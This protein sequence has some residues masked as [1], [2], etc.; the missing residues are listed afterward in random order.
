MDHGARLGYADVLFRDLWLSRTCRSD[1]GAR[2][3]L[4]SRPRMSLGIAGVVDE[5]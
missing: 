3:S 5:S 4:W 1:C 2:L